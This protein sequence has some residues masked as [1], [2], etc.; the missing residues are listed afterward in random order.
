MLFNFEIVYRHTQRH[1]YI[2][3]GQLHEVSYRKSPGG[4]MTTN[5]FGARGLKI[6][7]LWRELGGDIGGKA[8]N[9]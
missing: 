7:N 9:L 4:C 5:K 3:L 6:S 2:S 8:G 1:F